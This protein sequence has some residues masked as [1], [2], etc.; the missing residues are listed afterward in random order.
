VGIQTLVDRAQYCPRRVD[1]LGSIGHDPFHH[2]ADV[3]RLVTSF[4]QTA[5]LYLDVDGPLFPF[6]PPPSGCT[7]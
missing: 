1:R 3:V 2:A 4:T 7:L 6:G 5:L